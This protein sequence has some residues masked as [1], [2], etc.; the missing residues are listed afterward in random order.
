MTALALMSCCIVAQ[1]APATVHAI[2]RQES[3]G[4]SATVVATAPGRSLLLG[5]A[6]AYEGQ[7]RTK[8]I[9]LD[10]PVPGAAAGPRRASPRLLALDP[11]LDLSL[12]LPQDVLFWPGDIPGR[13]ILH[14]DRKMNESIPPDS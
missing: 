3:H 2:V 5:C 8:A 14:I 13:M 6:H 1:G 9:T 4:A 10:V 7:G 12:R 11:E